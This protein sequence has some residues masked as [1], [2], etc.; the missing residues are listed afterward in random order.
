MAADLQGWHEVS[1]REQLCTQE[2]RDSSRGTHLRL[3]PAAQSF[4]H[5]LQQQGC[6]ELGWTVESPL[7]LNLLELG[8][9]VG[10]LGM[11]VA[12]NVPGAHV[13]LTDLPG[14]PVCRL[15]ELV[16]QGTWNLSAP[17]VFALDWNDLI[18]RSERFSEPFSEPAQPA[19]ELVPG[20]ADLHTVFGTDLCWDYATVMALAGVLTFFTRSASS[21][22]CRPRVIYG[23][24]NRSSAITSLL[25][26]KLLARGLQVKVLHPTLGTI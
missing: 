11:M 20:L 2:Q 26:E 9:G 4:S 19:P 10:W 17:E 3:W 15:Q 6:A 18:P 8:S 5:W 12:R 23:H 1:P 24:W 7:D 21:A 22:A 13:T 14:Q 16:A 25:I